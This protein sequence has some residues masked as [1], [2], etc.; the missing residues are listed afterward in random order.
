MPDTVN[1]NMLYDQ[2]ILVID[3]F[4]ADPHFASISTQSY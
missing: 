1:P 3:E 4:V 2:S